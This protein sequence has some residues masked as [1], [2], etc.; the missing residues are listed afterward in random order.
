MDQRNKLFVGS[1]DFSITSDELRQAF[2]QHGT[3][4]EAVVVIDKFTGRSR[5]FGFVTFE[6]AEMAEAAASAMNE[7][8]LKGR[9]IV[10]SVARPQ[11]PRE[12]RGG[13]SRGGFKPRT[14]NRF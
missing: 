6:T 10:V 12:N 8:E 11:Q 2:E 4:V 1:L 7:T 13:F 9:K 3:V 5:G 14:Q